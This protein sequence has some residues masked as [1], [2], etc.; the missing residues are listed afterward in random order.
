MISDPIG[1]MLTRIRNSYQA[2]HGEVRLPHSKVKKE[3]ARVLVEEGFLRSVEVEKGTPNQLVLDLKYREGKQPAVT[4]IQRVS[5]PSRHLYTRANEIRSVL[6]GLG[7]VVISTSKGLMTGQQAR[8]K[9][10][11]GE[12]VCRVW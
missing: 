4:N 1:D 9:N 6:S 7:I 5:K 12:V 8:K 10:L 2:R 3:L 11:G